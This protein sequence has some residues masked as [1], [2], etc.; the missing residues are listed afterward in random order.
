MKLKKKLKLLLIIS[1]IICTMAVIFF[2]I[3]YRRVSRKELPIFAKQT[4][5]AKDGGTTIYKGLGYTVIDFNSIGGYDEIKIGPWNMSIYD[6][7]NER[8]YYEKKRQEDQNTIEDNKKEQKE[9]IQKGKKIK[10]NILDDKLFDNLKL[11]IG[12]IYNVLGKE[13]E[14]VVFCS[15]LS[16]EY[17]KV[18]DIFYVE[19]NDSQYVYEIV[20]SNIEKKSNSEGSET[21]LVYFDGVNEE[22]IK[23]TP[24][25]RRLK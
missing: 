25:I 7:E 14:I 23:V 19:T 17:P 1:I 15:V 3:D 22:D 11:N 10:A 8:E 2:I 12:D 4:S 21:L 16:G 24:Q 6:F 13:S 18:G 5:I 20:V 9:V